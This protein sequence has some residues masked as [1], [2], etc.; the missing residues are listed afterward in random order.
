MSDEQLP[1][2]PR[3]RVENEEDQQKS[4]S[5]ILEQEIDLGQRE[6]ER[7]TGGLLMSGL[8]AGLDIGFSVLA[9]TVIITLADD[10]FPE[11]STRLLAALAYSIGFVFVIFGRS[12]LY[13]EHT[14]LAFL[15]VLAGRARV[16]HLLRLW[17]LVFIANVAGTWAF[18]GLLAAIGPALGVIEPAA[19]GSEAVHSLEHSW[20][21]ILTSAILAGWLMGLASWLVTAARTTGAEIFFVVLVTSLIGLAELHHCI[22][23]SVKVLAAVF[24]TGELGMADY[25]RFMGLAT[26]GNTIGGVVFVAVIKYGHASRGHSRR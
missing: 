1:S 16:S 2:H 24:A 7:E 8:S 11:A 5:T 26:L 20:L 19:L 6:L 14:T 10:Q 17:A 4:Y 21:V 13:T 22:V 23:G 3:A 25:L 15:P 12:E 9:A 18:A